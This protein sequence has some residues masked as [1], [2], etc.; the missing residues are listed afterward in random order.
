MRANYS[1]K[2]HF[3]MALSCHGALAHP[4]TPHCKIKNDPNGSFSILV[5]VGGNLTPT[6]GRNEMVS[7]TPVFERKQALLML[8]PPK[9]NQFLPEMPNT[10]TA[11]L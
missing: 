10:C 4:P 8:I 11:L 5:G 9:F 7:D 2:F 6:I 3:R 1:R